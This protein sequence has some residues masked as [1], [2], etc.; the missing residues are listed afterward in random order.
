MVWS[1]KPQNEREQR[2]LDSGFP[3]SNTYLPDRW[4]RCGHC[5]KMYKGAGVWGPDYARDSDPPEAILEIVRRS[6]SSTGWCFEC[7]EKVI[8]RLP[9]R[10]ERQQ[11]ESSRDFEHDPPQLGSWLI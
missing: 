2:L 5:N 7:A 10:A 9:K 1:D 11:V 4:H 8:A 6:Q 3:I